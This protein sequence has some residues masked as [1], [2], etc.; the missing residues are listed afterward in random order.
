[1]KEYNIGLDTGVASVGWCVTDDNGGL[2][3]NRNK[4]LWGTRLFSEANT[5]AQTRTFRSSRR[6]N[7]RRKK[8]IDIL[9]SIL[10]DI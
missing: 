10:K 8:R 2:I 4:N 3:K 5:A 7:E 1:M 9:Q 6:R